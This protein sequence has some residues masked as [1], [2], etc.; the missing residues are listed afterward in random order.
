MAHCAILAVILVTSEIFFA[1]SYLLQ[2]GYH[3][4]TVHPLKMSSSDE[5]V[6][7]LP[8]PPGRLGIPLLED[9]TIQFAK[10]GSAYLASMHE[11][12]GEVFK[13]RLFF[14]EAVVVTGY[15]NLKKL[16]MSEH[17]L[18]EA[19]VPSAYAPL[20]GEM[21][22]FM[23]KGDEHRKLKQQLARGFTPTAVAGY[24]PSMQS[25]TEVFCEKWAD[26]GKIFGVSASKDLSFAIILEVVM[27]F[28]RALWTS[29]EASARIR[30]LYKQVQ[31]AMFAPPLNLPGTPFRRALEARRELLADIER[32]LLRVRDAGGPAAEGRARTVAA[33]LLSAVDGT[34]DQLSLE[35]IKDVCFNMLDA[36]HDTTGCVLS[37]L[38][39][40]LAD[41]PAALAALRAEQ[42]AVA[43]AHGPAL[44]D[45]ALRA[46]PFADAAIREALR[47]AS[48]APADRM[49]SVVVIN[50]KKALR[51][52]E[53]GG[54]RVPAGYTV[55]G[56]SARAAHS[57]PRW[58]GL[59]CTPLD[60]C[61]FCP[62]PGCQSP[63]RRRWS[64]A[65]S[66]RRPARTRFSSS[67][68]A[69]ASGA[70]ACD[71]GAQG[72]AGGAGPPI[73]LGAGRGPG[74]PP[75]R[76]KTD[77]LPSPSGSGPAEHCCCRRSPARVGPRGL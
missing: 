42:A 77:L 16:W 19:E 74:A 39:L 27:G 68:W 37:S 12:Y 75:P 60:K 70:R 23:T 55:I 54:F 30:E 13:Q 58:E 50:V 69:R 10:D 51:D 21:G 63:R 52:F 15:E 64:A 33:I 34:G 31:G 28:E 46:M 76:W 47:N 53:I 41:D 9:K 8:L 45:A 49:R 71:G 35:Q 11:K 32:C 6:Q 22:I 38:L 4:R 73:R 56:N 67:P 7:N 44:T 2:T 5:N 17:E 36:G 66:P 65:P 26:Q 57:D 40:S 43:A 14:T 20:L 61:R 25:L 72:G 62:A 29:E 18:V 24:L 1:D 48:P 59:D 3:F